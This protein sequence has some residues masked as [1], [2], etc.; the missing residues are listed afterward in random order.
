MAQPAVAKKVGEGYDRPEPPVL[1]VDIHYQ[2]LI[3]WLVS[4]AA[5]LAC[6]DA[7]W[8]SD[9]DLQRRD[10][11]VAGSV[12]SSH[13]LAGEACIGDPPASVCCV[14]VP[15]CRSQVARQKLPKDWHKRLQAIQAKAAQ[16]AKELP[17][18]VLQGLPGGAGGQDGPALDYYAAVQVRDRLAEGAE[19]TLFG[20]LTGPAATWDKIVKAYEKDCE[21]GCCCGGLVWDG[22]VGWEGGDCSRGRVGEEGAFDA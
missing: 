21:P 17:P 5:T 10:V 2:K 14:C 11:V 7:R 18:H 9:S 20:G 22:L 16:A 8:R 19:R 6:S 15:V 3:E 1:P 4:R 12:S 13:G